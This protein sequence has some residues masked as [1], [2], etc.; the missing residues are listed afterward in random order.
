MSVF[1]LSFSLPEISSLARYLKGKARIACAVFPFR[2]HKHQDISVK[3]HLYERK[4]GERPNTRLLALHTLTQFVHA[5]KSKCQLSRLANKVIRWFNETKAGGKD[6]EYRFTGRDSRMYL[7]HFMH[8]VASLESPTDSARQMFRLHTF[9]Y[10]SLQLRNAVSLFCRMT[11]TGSQ[12]QELT[13]YCTNYFRACSLFLG[14]V[15][16]TVWTIGHVVP[17]HAKDVNS[18]YGKGHAST[19]IEGREV[20]HIA[21]SRYS[22]NTNHGMRLQ[23]IFRHEFLSLIWPRERGYNLDNYIPFKERYVHNR[24]T[25]TNFCF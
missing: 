21:I 22:Q 17:V 24:V 2:R 14:K 5:L 15:T 4:Y 7:H 18:K 20:K 19:S 10:V 8:L 9:A 25:F 6:F 11:I 1:L 12:L 23:Q 3:Y 16:P 13:T